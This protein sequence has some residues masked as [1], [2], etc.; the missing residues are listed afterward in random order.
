MQP[1][2]VAN[3]NI[4]N[5]ANSP[6]FAYNSQ[7]S[8]ASSYVL[9][10]VSNALSP[11]STHKQ[12]ITSQG[13]L[14]GGG[15]YAH[16][17]ASSQQSQKNRNPSSTM[18]PRPS[19]GS[20]SQSVLPS[21]TITNNAPNPNSAQNSNGVGVVSNTAPSTIMQISAAHDE[22]WLPVEDD[23][24]ICMQNAISD[25]QF[26]YTIHWLNNAKGISRT[27]PRSAEEARAR[28]HVLCQS[29]KKDT[30]LKDPNVHR[31]ILKLTKS[32][33]RPTV[34]TSVSTNPATVA[35]VV[36]VSEKVSNEVERTPVTAEQMPSATEGS[37][38][39]RVTS[40]DNDS[41]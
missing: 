2:S 10:G 9:P 40:V 16:A 24:M 1:S 36:S 34:G 26:M 27:A 37:I 39:D 18:S 19:N 6:Y 22:I 3:D 33:K 25:P 38:T 4:H 32:M 20:N 17:L 15:Q 14:L 31:T 23:I 41:V 28:Y 13:V 8:A 29:G 35:S 7:A 30:R 12:N 21:S 5:P 11:N